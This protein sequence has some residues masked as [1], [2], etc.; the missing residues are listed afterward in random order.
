MAP[1]T[2]KSG[3]SHQIKAENAGFPLEV[4]ELAAKLLADRKVLTGAL[5]LKA[6]GNIL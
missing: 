2:A 4:V 5:Y 3:T 1:V 6:C